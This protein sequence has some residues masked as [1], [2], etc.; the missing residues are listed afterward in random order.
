MLKTSF[1]IIIDRRGEPRVVCN[2]RGKK[3]RAG[4]KN[5]SQALRC[6]DTLFL[7]FIQQCLAWDPAKRL[8]PET[9]FQHEWIL[10][11]TRPTAIRSTAADEESQDRNQSPK[12]TCNDTNFA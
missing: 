1:I 4:T 11:S 9:A 3:R 5:L 10:Q 7:D 8:N 12:P 6:N 2:S